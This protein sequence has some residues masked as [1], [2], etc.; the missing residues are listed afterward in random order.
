[1]TVVL[2]R[3]PPPVVPLLRLG[4]EVAVFV[5]LALFIP[6]SIAGAAQR[7][8]M[9]GLSLIPTLFYAALCALLL[10]ADLRRTSA[11]H[12]FGSL[13]VSPWAIAGCAVVPAV[14]IET[15]LHLLLWR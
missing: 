14:A 15:A 3:L 2:R 13:G 7:T 10:H 11:A 12:L 6:M 9:S 8:P 1:M 5:R 4:F